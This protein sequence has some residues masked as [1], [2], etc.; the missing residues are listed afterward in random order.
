MLAVKKQKAEVRE[1][2][3]HGKSRASIQ[4]GCLRVPKR[5][6]NQARLELPLPAKL[7]PPSES[8]DA[9]PLEEKSVEFSRCGFSLLQTLQSNSRAFSHLRSSLPPASLAWAPRQAEPSSERSSSHVIGCHGAATAVHLR[10]CEEVVVSTSAGGA[11]ENL[12][13]AGGAAENLPGAPRL[14]LGSALCPNSLRE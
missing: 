6:D 7:L 10:C 13:G 14:C 2:A 11:A 8:V 12:P 9:S 4:P 3:S 5:G 1:V